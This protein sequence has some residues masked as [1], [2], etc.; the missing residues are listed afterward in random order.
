MQVSRQAHRARIDWVVPY[1]IRGSGGHRT[2]FLH[3]R[4]LVAR[5]FRCVMHIQDRDPHDPQSTRKNASE[6][7]EMI[8]NWFFET[9]AEVV[10]TWDHLGPCDILMATLWESAYVVKRATG[11]KHKAYFVQDFEACFSP[12][13]DGYLM[14]ENS[15]RLGLECITIGRFLTHLIRNV[16]HGSAG[17]FDFTVDD[18]IYY[19]DLSKKSD[20]PSVAFLYQPEKPRRCPAIG[21]EALKIVKAQCPEA[22]IFVYGSDVPSDLPFE[23]THLGLISPAE[24]ARLYQQINVG[25]CISASNPSRIPF[26]LLATGCAV[27]D[28]DRSNNHFD[29]P[30]G[31]L[32]L[33]E[34]TPEALAAAMLDLLTHRERRMQQVQIGLALMSE[35]PSRLGFEQVEKLIDNILEHGAVQPREEASQKECIPVSKSFGFPT[36]EITKRLFAPDDRSST[37]NQI[38]PAARLGRSQRVSYASVLPKIIKASRNKAVVGLDVFD[39]LISRRVEPE[40]IKMLVAHRFAETLTEHNIE[41]SADILYAQRQRI[42]RELCEANRAAG[43]DDEFDYDTMLEWWLQEANSPDAYRDALKEQLHAYE[44]QIELASQVVDPRVSVL[45]ESLYRRGKRLVFVSDFYLPKA[46]VWRFLKQAKLDIYFERGYCSSDN[47]LRK[48]SGR[49]FQHVLEDLQVTPHKML[50]V[51]DNPHSDVRQATRK[52]IDVLHLVE[53]SLKRRYT[54]LNVLANMCEQNRYWQGGLAHE[55]VTNFTESSPAEEANVNYQ[56]GYA[57]APAYVLFVEHLLESAQRDKIG[58]LYF[59]AREGMM[60]LRIARK[61]IGRDKTRPWPSLHY[62]AVSRRSTFLPTLE[63]LSIPALSRLLGQYTSISPRQFMESVGLGGLIYEQAWHDTGIEDLDTPIDDIGKSPTL[64]SFLNNPEVQQQFALDHASAKLLFLQYLHQEGFFTHTR[65]RIVDIGWKGSIIDNVA[66]IALSNPY[67]PHIDGVLLGAQADMTSP[68]CPKYG[69]IF[70]GS[71]RDTMTMTGMTNVALFESHATANHGSVIGYQHR[72]HRIR[73]ILR[74]YAEERENWQKFMRYGQAGVHA[75]VR[76]YLRAR[77]FLRTAYKMSIDEWLPVIQDKLRRIVHHPKASEVQAFM[78]L[79][80]VE[81]FGKVTVRRFADERTL[82]KQQ[83]GS[84]ARSPNGLYRAIRFTLWPSAI[85]QHMRLG[86]LLRPV[87]NIYDM[88]HRTHR[89]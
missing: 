5:G 24:C 3:I 46:D 80:H 12:M 63:E 84:M 81:S 48:A 15:Y 11:A 50:F 52:G 33:V 34:P 49:L 60:F 70:D 13:S 25:L 87:Y 44:V 17:Y 56:L 30:T 31:A 27:V 32:S 8:R 10:P 22:Q 6:L 9:H 58:A 20:Q 86:F 64:A 43:H 75:Y 36:S 4:D 18:A 53:P 23:H 89:W 76:D 47:F 21:R 1:P 72:N 14:A 26:E 45:L 57:I 42:E 67:H 73:P 38:P 59:C 71:R 82:V 16:Y 19:P 83:G 79:T 85:M 62:L 28:V 7:Q 29:Y 2:I 65:V 54:R 39:T 74:S 88:W 68:I 69:Y 41:I 40:A 66:R 51:G 37:A 77:P 61:I 35:R 78:N 55:I